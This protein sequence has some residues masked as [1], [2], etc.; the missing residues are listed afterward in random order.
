MA[1]RK[2]ESST[3]DQRTLEGVVERSKDLCSV[4]E[5]YPL[6]FNHIKKLLESRFIRGRRKIS[7]GGGMLE[8]RTEAGTSEVMTQELG[9][10]NP[11]LTF[12]QANCQAIDSAQLQNVSKMLNM[13][14]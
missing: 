13:R 2:A 6:E 5:K 11:K 8:E 12:A 10:R 14:R 1:W 4:G 3:L 7:D 9:L